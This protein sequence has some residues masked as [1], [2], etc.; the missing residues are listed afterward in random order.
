LLRVAKLAGTR[1]P[2]REELRSIS[3]GPRLVPR[4]AG[5]T[6]ADGKVVIRRQLNRRY[7]LA[8]FQKRRAWLALMPGVAESIA[9]RLAPS[10]ANS[11]S[12]ESYRER[13]GSAFHRT[14]LREAAKPI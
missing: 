13:R 10:I 11:D 2:P 12:E 7:V 1:R 9:G 8:F 4:F 6:H 3:K 5:A 14:F